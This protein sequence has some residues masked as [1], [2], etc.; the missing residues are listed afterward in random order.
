MSNDDNKKVEVICEEPAY[1]LYEDTPGVFEILE[2]DLEIL[3]E[4]QQPIDNFY[5]EVNEVM[6]EVVG[7]KF[8]LIGYRS[9]EVNEYIDGKVRER[10]EADPDTLFIC[11]DRFLMRNGFESRIARFSVTRT[12]NED[13]S[14]GAQVPRQGELPVE[15][16][17]RQIAD[18]I[19]RNGVRNVVLVDDGFYTGSTLKMLM[20]GLSELCPEVTFEALG[21]ILAI[22]YFEN[23]VAVTAKNG[24]TEID[25]WIELRDLVMQGKR[26]KASKANNVTTSVPYIFPWVENY[27]LED[28]P[29]EFEASIRLIE[30]QRRLFEAYDNLRAERERGPVTI[31]ELVRSGFPIPTNPTSTLEVSIDESVVDYLDRCIQMVRAEMERPVLIADMDGT[32]QLLLQE[33]ETLE[34][35]GWQGSKLRAAVNANLLS[36]VMRMDV[37]KKKNL[38]ISDREA[39]RIV[40]EAKA[41]GR[42]LSAYFVDRYGV[43]RSEYFEIVWDIQ[44]EGIIDVEDFVAITALRKYIKERR[45]VDNPRLILLTAAP[46]IWAERVIKYLGAEDLFEVIR[47]GETYGE[48]DEIFRILAGKYKVKRII[49]IG[50]QQDTD[51]D[52]AVNLG[53]T[54]IKVD[55]PKDTA[56]KVLALTN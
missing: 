1:V 3:A 44:P 55:G 36:Y 6:A 2:D 20:G 19:N 7:D 29:L 46:K 38:N 35:A 33:D 34:S 48:K 25:S 39:A 21:F 42:G 30:A 23:G 11:L 31:K 32:L 26:L 56:G 12:V 5:K 47:T 13:G 10:C 14:T 53:M 18:Y 4:M 8:E 15:Q 37:E 17:I 28:T 9:D 49:T 40:A 52:P 50:D 54:G 41:Y 51:I 45:D 27:A 16:Q 22:N 43:T 24:F